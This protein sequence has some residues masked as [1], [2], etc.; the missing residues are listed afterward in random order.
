MPLRFSKNGE[1]LAAID[2]DSKLVTL[3]LETGEPETQLQL[4]KNLQAFCP[5]H[6][7][8]IS[9]CWS[10]RSQLDFAFGICK[11]RSQFRSPIRTTPNHRQSFLPTAQASCRP[12]SR[13]P[14]CGGTCGISQKHHCGSLAKPRSFLGTARSSSHSLVNH[15]NAGTQGREQPRRSSRSTLPTVFLLRSRFRMTAAFWRGLRSD[16]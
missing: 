1:T 7:V 13:V 8:K 10:S 2:D 6:S 14:F 4:S 9:G 15:S 11:R 3:N 12:E 16:Q 5:P